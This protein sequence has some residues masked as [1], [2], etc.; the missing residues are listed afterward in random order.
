MSGVAFI[1]CIEECLHVRGGLYEGF[2]CSIS[3]LASTR[4]MLW[5]EEIAKDIKANLYKCSGQFLIQIPK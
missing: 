1:E 3:P 2:H 4:T 5:L